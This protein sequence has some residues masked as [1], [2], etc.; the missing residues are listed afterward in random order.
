MWGG[1]SGRAALKGG[2][3]QDCPPH[4][5]FTLRS[6]AEGLENLAQVHIDYAVFDAQYC[7]NGGGS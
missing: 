3:R 6:E 5:W 1:Q 2:C 4:S 7:F